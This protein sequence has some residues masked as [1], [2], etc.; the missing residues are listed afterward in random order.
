MHRVRNQKVQ[1]VFEFYKE[2]NHLYANV[3]QNEPALLFDDADAAAETFTEQVEDSSGEL[4]DGINREQETIRGE[5]DEFRD[6]NENNEINVIERRLGISDA[7][8]PAMIQEH[9]AAPEAGDRGERRFEVR[10]SNKISTDVS[11]DLFARMFPH[12]FPFGRGHP[13]E[14]RPV[15]VSV[16]ECVKYYTMLS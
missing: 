1:E 12:L 6:F 16:H 3:L 15:A 9:P 5:N 11:G 7:F 2:N 13:G 14:A 10:G 8:V 4:N